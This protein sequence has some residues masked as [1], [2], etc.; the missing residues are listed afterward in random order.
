[1]IVVLEAL[2]SN[3]NMKLFSEFTFSQLWVQN[4][5]SMIKEWHFTLD[6]LNIQFQK[7]EEW[8][9]LSKLFLWYWCVD[10][11]L[12]KQCHEP[13]DGCQH[14]QKGQGAPR[15]SAFG[16]FLFNMFINSLDE[17]VKIVLVNSAVD[18]CWEA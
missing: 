15:S 14:A 5:S 6:K 18:T 1:M 2:H 16:P 8:F 11:E 3:S 17:D 13:V 10:L 4:L 9:Y 12:V 7:H